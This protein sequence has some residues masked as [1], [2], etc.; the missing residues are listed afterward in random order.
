MFK[1]PIQFLREVIEEL[2]KVSWS[3]RKQTIGSTM[4]VILLV[5][6]VA[7]FVGLVDFGL[8]IILGILIK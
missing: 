7:I 8:S 6:A 5:I 1:K 2:R 4:V 3:D